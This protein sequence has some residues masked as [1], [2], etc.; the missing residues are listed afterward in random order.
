MASALVFFAHVLSVSAETAIINIIRHGEKCKGVGDD[1]SETGYA[2]AAYLARCM[3]SDTPSAAMPFGKA[4]AVMSG[5][6]THSRRPMET[7]KPLAEKL[8]VELPM[9]CGTHDVDCFVENALR[10]LTDRGTLVVGWSHHH[11]PRLVQ[12]LKFPNFMNKY[13]VWPK[14]CPSAT[15]KEPECSY[16][17][18][19]S[20]CY[21]AIWQIKFAR[22]SGNSSWYPQSISALAE[23]F[24]GMSSSHCAQDLAPIKSN[25]IVRFL[26]LPRVV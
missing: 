8:G 25:V 2:R 23:G 11:M 12:A 13:P 16:D 26:E 1:L 15:F 9:P 24:G 22:K 14:D 17:D 21:D 20:V 5:D 6:F 3:S 7:V 19:D 4:T 18:G 10:Y